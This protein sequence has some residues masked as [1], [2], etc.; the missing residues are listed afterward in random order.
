MPYRSI[1]TP[2]ATLDLRVAAAT[3]WLAWQALTLAQS[4]SDHVTSDKPVAEIGHQTRKLR[5]SIA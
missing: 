2:F 5:P 1:V 3:L 4:P